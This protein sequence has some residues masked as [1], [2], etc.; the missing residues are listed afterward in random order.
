VAVDSQGQ[1]Y[2][3]SGAAATGTA[4][5]IRKLG[6]DGRL[7]FY[8]QLKGT[9][10]AV[11]KVTVSNTGNSTM[12]LT[13][14]QIVGTN[15]ADFKID[16]TTTSC[17]LTPGST[18][19]SGQSCQIGVLFTPS[20]GGG[21]SAT[22]VFLD[23]TVNN[24]NNVQLYG[25]GTLAPTFAITSPATGTSVKAGTAVV[26]SV[27]VTSSSSPAPT[28]T[29]KFWVDGV[30]IGSPVTLNASGAASV[31]VTETTT[32]THTLAASYNGNG[33]YVAAGPITRTY[34]VTAAAVAPATSA[35]VL[36]SSA[37]PAVNCQPLA[38]SATVNGTSGITPTGTVVLKKGATV[39]AT[40][41]LSN[42]VAALSTAAL[43]PGSNVLTASY[44]GDARY[45]ASSS[46][47]F[48]QVISLK[49][50]CNILPRR[51]PVQ[52][53]PPSLPVKPSPPAVPGR[54]PS[55]TF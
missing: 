35:T 51:L 9:T 15:A 38:F 47:E 25:S 6:P 30:A 54:F 29:V 24:Q 33:I 22:L 48:T 43:P 4:Q 1:V 46:A 53:L 8:G 36:T 21:R 34:T 45:G 50:T 7:T 27:S 5:V 13:S 20:A 23:N 52:L 44:G 14:A 28:G 41:T 40:A 10:S 37:N 16:P 3:I 39:L 26:F 17:M 49:N 18:L 42:G 12:T 32:G 11:N 2:I 55:T 19:L 31:S